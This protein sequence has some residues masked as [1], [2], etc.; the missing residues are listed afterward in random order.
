MIDYIMVFSIIH[1]LFSTNSAI[2][3]D[4]VIWQMRFAVQRI[5]L[6]ILHSVVTSDAL[7]DYEV[8]QN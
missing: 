5:V 3:L 2:K 7:S 6:N 1:A 4:N 8:R